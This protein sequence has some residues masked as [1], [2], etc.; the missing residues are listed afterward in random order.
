[1]RFLPPVF[2]TVLRPC[3]ASGLVRGEGFAVDATVIEAD[4]SRFKHPA[5]LRRLGKE[6]RLIVAAH[7]PA[8]NLDHSPI[9]AISRAHRWFD[10]LWFDILKSREV[11][12]ISDLARAEKLPRSYVS[13]LVPLA[14]LA[15]DIT[16]AILVGQ[17]PLEVTLDRILKLAPLP[18]PWAD[19]RKALGI[20]D[21]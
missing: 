5:D 13:S 9:K 14:F 2:E 16:E 12:S 1:M 7:A 18:L 19:Q 6:K 4:A 17:Q 3:M 8:A 10:I 15:P 11:L 21:R 20:T